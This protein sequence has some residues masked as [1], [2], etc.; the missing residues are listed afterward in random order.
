MDMETDDD[1]SLYDDEEPTWPFREKIQSYPSGSKEAIS[2]YFL[3]ED[4]QNGR[5]AAPAAILDVYLRVV[6]M[7]LVDTVFAGAP[8]FE[9]RA[10]GLRYVDEMEGVGEE[11]HCTLKHVYNNP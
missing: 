8:D 4:M 5:V 11:P 3:M 9:R 1:F 10:P 6:A 2:V 7:A